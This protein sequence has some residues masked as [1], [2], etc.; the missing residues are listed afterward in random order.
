MGTHRKVQQ[1]GQYLIE[2]SIFNLTQIYK[3]IHIKLH[4]HYIDDITT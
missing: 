2:Y 3:S 4:F 1:G